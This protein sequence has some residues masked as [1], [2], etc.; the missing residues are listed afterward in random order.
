MLLRLH[1]QLSSRQWA[2]LTAIENSPGWAT[3]SQAVKDKQLGSKG[4]A[5]LE[6]GERV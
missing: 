3:A 2:K 5:C 1:P 6:Y 4:A